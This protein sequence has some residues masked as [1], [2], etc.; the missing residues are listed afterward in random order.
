[1]LFVFDRDL[2]IENEHQV[3]HGL[4]AEGQ[5]GHSERLPASHDSSLDLALGIAQCKYPKALER[6][7]CKVAS[8]SGKN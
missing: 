1:M 7:W 3:V 5:D 2:S 6:L 4:P 8:T